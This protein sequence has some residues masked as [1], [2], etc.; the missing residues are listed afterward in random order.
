MDASK[1][2]KSN[3]LASINKVVLYNKA[4]RV[5]EVHL[6]SSRWR[7]IIHKGRGKRKTDVELY[8]RKLNLD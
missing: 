2:Y 5:K 7:G 4:K 8:S 1:K 3:S 6:S